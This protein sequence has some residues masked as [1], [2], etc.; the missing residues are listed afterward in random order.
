MR[1]VLEFISE[2]IVSSLIFVVN[3]CVKIVKKLRG[4]NKKSMYQTDKEYRE[5][6]FSDK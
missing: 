5:S 6:I 4:K 3:I 2:V 1:A